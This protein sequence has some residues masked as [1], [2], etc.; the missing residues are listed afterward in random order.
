M[1]LIVQIP[2]HNEEDAL[3]VTI[4]TIPRH[5]PGVDKV[6]ILVIDDGSRDR[7]VQVARALGVEHVVRHTSNKG[8]A[9]AFQTGLDACLR[10]GADLIVN[11]DA[12]NQYPQDRIPDLIAPILRH[13]ADMVIGDRQVQD[14]EHF[15]PLKKFL[16]G[17][18][19]RVVGSASGTRVP[20]APSGFR[21]FS[22]EAALQL[23]V[24]TK[25]TYTLETIIQAGKKNIAVAHVPIKTNPEMRKSRLVRSIPD[26]VKKSGATIVRIWVLYE[27][28]KIFSYIAG[29]FLF[30]GIWGVFWLLFHWAVDGP[31]HFNWRATFTNHLPTTF[32]TILALVFGIQIFLIGLLADILAA[33]RRI[34][35]DTLYRVKRMELE[36]SELGQRGQALV[37]T[38][39][40]NGVPNPDG[41][42]TLLEPPESKDPIIADC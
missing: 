22:R 2:C 8:L 20:D 24:I 28:L 9:A 23:N 11:T 37:E 27:P 34:T 1:K 26:Y 16:Q 39:P 42:E 32:A 19:S 36:L 4:P 13:E 10:L 29:I 21:A 3:P 5:I 15:S 40:P 31:Q 6:E 18:G 38:P 25:Y 33:S 14:I 41:Q 30:I 12:D 17:L 7:T 35:E